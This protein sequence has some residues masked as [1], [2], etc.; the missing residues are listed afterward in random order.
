MKP[1]FIKL[2]EQREIRFSNKAIL[3]F[4]EE[5]GQ[6]LFEAL[7]GLEEVDIATSVL[8]FNQV[9]YVALLAKN[10]DIE[11]LEQVIDLVDEHLTFEVLN[12][13]CME[14]INESGFFKKADPKKKK[15]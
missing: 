13:K 1:I 12:A 11:S 9:L 4:K 8:F 3:K 5:T 10:D 7:E 6:T 2:D 14:A 15:K